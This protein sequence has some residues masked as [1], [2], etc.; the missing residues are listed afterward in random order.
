MNYSQLS[1]IAVPVGVVGIVLLLV[2]PI[3]AALLDILFATS[4]LLSLVVLLLT[5]FAKRPLDFSVFP[6]LLLV[7]TLLRLGLNVASTRLVLSQGYAGEVIEAFG[8]ITIGGSLVIGFVIF[9]ILVVIQF[10]VVTKGA[11]RVAEVG[12]R[13]TLDAMPGK[14]M[15]I[16]ADLNAGLITDSQARERRAEVAA[17][18]DFYG[19]MDGA[20]KFVK[21]DAIAGLVIIIINLLGGIGIGMLSRG[22]EI[23]DALNT[24]ALLTIGDGLATQIPALLMAVSTGMIVTRSNSADDMGATAS[25]QLGQSRAALLIAGGCAVALALVPGMPKLPFVF[26]GG[27]LLW[28]AGRIKARDEKQ[29]QA[30]A[31]AAAE[32]QGAAPE[33]PTELLERMKVHA[34]E[35]QLAADL[36]DVVNGGGD[37]LLARV[38]ALRRRIAMD[39]GIVLPPVRTRDNVELPP[40]TYAILIAGVEA[41]RGTAP[42]GKVLALGDQLDSLPG[43]LVHEPVFGLAGK[44]VPAELRHTADMAGATTID[45]I[46]VIITHLSSIVQEQAPRLLTR[47]D[48]RVM[49]DALREQSP[50]AVEELVPSLLS[51]A[52][53]QRVLQGLLGEAVAI[54]DLARIFEALSLQAKTGTAP[55]NLIEAAR[56]ALGPA[57]A[58]KYLQGSTLRVVMI[59]PVVEQ[60]MLEALRPGDAGSQIM[61]DARRLE[62]VLDSVKK[63]AADLQNRG[64]SAVLVCAPALRPAVRRL[65]GPASG[66]DAVLSYQEATAG[67]AQIETVGVVRGA[68]AISA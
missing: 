15:A 68:D 52:E 55:E 54:N 33:T 50:S 49:T 11:E 53:V 26:I 46:S 47:E 32:P 5:M 30:D 19:A 64:V 8:H 61:F 27:L 34:I 37:D 60:G 25:A 17:E 66:L 7:A 40:A 10:V 36:V 43:Q 62:A 23:T 14:Q 24:Y 9:L 65:I 44:W 38:R 39:L 21:G 63:I 41:G 1:K 2:V 6:S 29:A 20:S 22:M 59:D 4:I 57:I 42:R 3:P 67:G 56:E 51:L 31:Q 12:A 28:F 45:R 16:D 35:V 58:A 13:F 18:A 48:V